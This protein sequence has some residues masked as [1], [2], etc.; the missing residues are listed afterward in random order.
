MCFIIMNLPHT[1]VSGTN[2]ICTMEEFHVLYN[3]ESATHSSMG[4][5][6]IPYNGMIDVLHNHESATLSSM[7]H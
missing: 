2:I 4:H 7:G 3:H 6:Y 5:Q 1:L